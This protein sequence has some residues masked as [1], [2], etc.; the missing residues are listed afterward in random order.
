MKAP[1]K[2]APTKKAPTETAPSK[3]DQ[4]SKITRILSDL[5]KGANNIVDIIED[6]LF[7]EPSQKKDI[8]LELDLIAPDHLLTDQ[9]TKKEILAHYGS[10]LLAILNYE[11]K[12]E[13]NAIIKKVLMNALK[14]LSLIVNNI[15]LI[16]DLKFYRLD[17][18]DQRINLINTISKILA[19]AKDGAYRLS[20]YS[21]N[22]DQLITSSNSK[23]L[24][25]KNKILELNRSVDQDGIPNYFAI[26]LNAY[27]NDL[28]KA[29][30]EI[31]IEYLAQQ[32]K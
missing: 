20:T 9:S 14:S 8:L 25:S 31:K 22:E 10:L 28:I 21:Y 30:N 11:F 15:S 7:F 12:K 13:K 27:L 19:I 29:N 17:T 1:N 24:L 26:N 18:I 32:I 6:I 2:K 4:I 5:H 3:K 23:P 16:I